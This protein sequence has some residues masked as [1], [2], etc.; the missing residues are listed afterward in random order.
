MLTPTRIATCFNWVSPAGK[1]RGQ[2]NFVLQALSVAWNLLHRLVS[3]EGMVVTKPQSLI[4][5]FNT[6]SSCYACTHI[7]M[8]SYLVSSHIIS[9]VR[10]VRLSTWTVQNTTRGPSTGGYESSSL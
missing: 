3:S 8:F 6:S 7:P 9:S 2:G 4:D 10:C 5:T 1:S